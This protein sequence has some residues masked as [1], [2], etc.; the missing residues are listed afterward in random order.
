M[1]N[2]TGLAQHLLSLDPAKQPALLSLYHF[3]KNLCEAGDPVTREL[4]NSFYARALSFTH[5]QENKARLF[6]D[7]QTAIMSFAAADPA[8][9]ET[10]LPGL[11]Q[12][13][14]A[15]EIQVVRLESQASLVA[16]LNRKFETELSPP[17]QFRVFPE[18]ADRAV[19]IVLGT[20][21]RLRVT[22]FHPIAKIL[23][24]NLTPLCTDYTLHYGPDLL[25]DPGK[26]Q[27]I[28]IGAHTAARFRF[29]SDGCKGILL[30]GYTFQRY[31]AM[32]GGSLHRYPVLFYP[33]KRIEQFFINRKSDPMYVELTGI[34]EKA[35]ELLSQG[36][37]EGIKFGSQALE[38]GKLALE[39][40]FPD[41]KL[42]RLLINNLEKTLALEA[43]RRERAQSSFEV[44]ESRSAHP[45]EMDWAPGASAGSWAT[46]AR[47]GMAAPLGSD[48][49]EPGKESVPSWEKTKP[50]NNSSVSTNISPSAG[51]RAGV[52]PMN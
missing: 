21:K 20:D 9:A 7:T 5:W 41:D 6:E 40:I 16:M 11:A 1:M 50:L 39:H 35:A 32:D 3:L 27:Q 22:L 38:R 31:A 25:L 30:R 17:E 33:L 37:P 4:L 52:K 26:L 44:A 24:G 28:E 23:E 45:Q 2:V 10:V 13:W 51:S 12:A 42:V 14:K 49:T 34:L 18:C 43:A 8:E 29:T 15:T 48:V 19:V 46:D 47:T 36:H